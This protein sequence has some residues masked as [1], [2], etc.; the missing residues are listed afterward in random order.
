[1]TAAATFVAEHFA[2]MTPGERAEFFL[3]IANEPSFPQAVRQVAYDAV[4]EINR[5]KF[6]QRVAEL[7][8]KATE[9]VTGGL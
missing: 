5:A 4:T 1:M 3:A 8:S 2:T 7:A 9:H 6:H